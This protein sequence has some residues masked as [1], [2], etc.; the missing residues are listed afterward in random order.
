MINASKI[1]EDNM[2]T[3]IQEL[4][5][6]CEIDIDKDGKKKITPKDKIKED[7]GRS[8]DWADNFAMRMWFELAPTKRAVAF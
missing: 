7:L 8:P 1:G 5:V 2:N 6:M 4:D 3:L